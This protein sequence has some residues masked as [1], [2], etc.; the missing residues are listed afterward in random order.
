[1]PKRGPITFEDGATTLRDPGQYGCE[2]CNYASPPDEVVVRLL[3]GGI[4]GISPEIRQ[5]LMEALN[6]TPDQCACDPNKFPTDKRT[7][8]KEAAIRYYNMAMEAMHSKEQEIKEKADKAKVIIEAIIGASKSEVAQGIADELIFIKNIKIQDIVH[9]F[10]ARKELFTDGKNPTMDNPEKFE[11]LIRLF[12]ARKPIKAY[13]RKLLIER[14]ELDELDLIRIWR[15]KLA[16]NGKN[17][18]ESED[19]RKSMVEISATANLY[20]STFFTPHTLHADVE[21]CANLDELSE[22]VRTTIPL[23]VDK[24]RKLVSAISKI[25]MMHLIDILRS[26]IDFDQM[27][28]VSGHLQK[29]MDARKAVLPDMRELFTCGDPEAAKASNSIIVESIQVAAEKKE[30]SAARKYMD[31]G[32]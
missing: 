13:L 16:S 14:S 31:K 4:E 30:E 11:E 24:F 8:C 26:Q 21:Q 20:C 2:A 10:E 23:T 7:V 29:L 1:M 27:K 25:N 17:S 9:T 22:I 5:Q 28:K 32:S 6:P 3:E 18:A 19:A 15:E 12:K